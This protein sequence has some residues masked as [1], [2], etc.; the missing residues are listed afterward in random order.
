MSRAGH[1]TG[2]MLVTAS[3]VAWSL[4]G[5]FTRL[6]HLDNWTMLAWRGIFGALG[7]AAA[8]MVL[9]QRNIWHSLRK[10]GWLGWVFVLQSALGM[11]FYLSA[12]THTS[13]ANVAV[14]YATAPFL[15]A[16]LGWMVLREKP[17]T[18]SIVASLAALVGV[19]I[20]VGFGKKGGVLGDLLALG[21]TWSMA[22]TMV[23]ARNYRDIPILL[24]ACIASLLSGVSSWPFGAPFAITGHELMLLAL[25]GIV[26]FAIALPLFTFGARLLPAIETALIG[27]VDAPLAPLW[28]WLAFNET[29]SGSTLIGG[30]IVFA[31]VAIHLIVGETFPGAARRQIVG[32]GEL[33]AAKAA[34]PPGRGAQRRGVI[35]GV[36]VS[37]SDVPVQPDGL[38]LIAGQPADGLLCRQRLPPEREAELGQSGVG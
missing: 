8:M 23:V 25:F 26:N 5:L 14:I 21:M 20:M 9:R 31:A 7:L 32:L 11:T 33:N 34:A 17:T 18:S 27:A 6:I 2:F 24:T 30:T 35:P 37:I 13:V 29:P 12:L 36:D 38:E 28:V 15:A 19:A 4:G 1:R 22:S 3:A 16:G 10:M